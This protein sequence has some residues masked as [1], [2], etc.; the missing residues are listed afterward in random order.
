VVSGID[1]AGIDSVSEWFPA[2][3]GRT[4][5][6]TP[7]GLEWLPGGVYAVTLDRHAA[8]QACAAMDAA[9]LER[10]AAITRTSFTHVL[11]SRP[12]S[13]PDDEFAWTRLVA[14]LRGSPGYALDYEDG[15]AA[16]FSVLPTAASP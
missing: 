5:V 14:S 8:L 4:S 1:A 7:Q 16:I 15:D 10:W 13:Q 3:A 6:A 11:V 12:S 9:C 2:L